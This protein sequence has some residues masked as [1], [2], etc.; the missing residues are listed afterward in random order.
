M[1]ISYSQI[2]SEARVSVETESERHIPKL[3]KILKRY[4]PDLVQLHGTLEKTPRRTEFGVSL[5]LTL[6]TGS[7]Q[8]TGRGGDARI[9]TKAAFAELEGQLKK[10][11]SKL[12]R[13]YM[14][15]RKRGARGVLKA[16]EVPSTD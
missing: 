2:D 11:Q 1:K 3:E 4:D 13:D 7:L 14:W 16:S 12:R 9:A 8:A 15:K 5:H 10:H 6:P